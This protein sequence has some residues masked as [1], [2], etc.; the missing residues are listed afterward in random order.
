[1]NDKYNIP[2]ENYGG[3]REKYLSWDETFMLSAVVTSSRSKDP[4]S[5]VGACIVG[6][7]NRILSL[8]Y[9]GAP[10]GWNDDE[11]PDAYRGGSSLT[12]CN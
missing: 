12:R 10:N 2:K 4:S 7:D 8:G 6:S 9:N 3:K 5:Q 1:M 11:F